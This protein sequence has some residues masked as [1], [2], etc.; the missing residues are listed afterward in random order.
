[1]LAYASGRWSVLCLFLSIKANAP[2]PT[3]ILINY[4]PDQASRRILETPEE[5]GSYLSTIFLLSATK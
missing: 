3:L 5:C 4:Q 1:M 2:P